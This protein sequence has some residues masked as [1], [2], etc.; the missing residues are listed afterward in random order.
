M[1]VAIAV[2]AGLV[3]GG[4]AIRLDDA[5]AEEDFSE[6]K[7]IF[8]R[9]KCRVKGQKRGGLFRHSCAKSWN[10]AGRCAWIPEDGCM[11]NCLSRFNQKKTLCDPVDC[12]WDDEERRCSFLDGT[13][14]DRTY[15]CGNISVILNKDQ[16][17]YCTGV[18]TAA[19]A[20][21]LQPQAK[22]IDIMGF[23][24]CWYV[25]ANIP[26]FLDAGSTNNIELYTWNERRQ[27]IDVTFQYTKN[28]KD[29][30]SYQKGWTKNEANTLWRLH[31]R[32]LWV[33]WPLNLPY[34][35]LYVAD[36]FSSSIVG[37]PDRS[38]LWIMTRE[39]HPDPAEVQRLIGIAEANG[40]RQAD[41]TM[42][43]NNINGTPSICP[44]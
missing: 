21:E 15:F 1:K 9:E 43:Q 32:L 42:V 5:L 19:R 7:W 3:L 35:L 18:S 25:Q 40:Y 27:R 13:E 41:M 6:K 31:P 23:M 37:Y 38:Y 12:V 14:R 26:T 44:Q 22:A 28:G 11:T 30:L 4:A 33:F 16:L 8:P 29:I 34:V 2:I 10:K 39:V 36:D 17:S 20:T 24:G